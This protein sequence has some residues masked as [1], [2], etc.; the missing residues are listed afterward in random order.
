[1]T[2]VGALVLCGIV[3][4]IAMVLIVIYQI[5]RASE[6]LENILSQLTQGAGGRPIP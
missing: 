3:V 4:L 1:M 5:N 6:D 2:I